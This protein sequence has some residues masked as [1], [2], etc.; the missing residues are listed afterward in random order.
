MKRF[1]SFVLFALLWLPL[2]ILFVTVV[3]GMPI[4]IEPQAWL[5]LAVV[6]P[7]GLPLALA[8][9]ALRRAGHPVSAWA[10]FVVLAPATAVAALFAGLLGPLGIAIYAIV[11]SLPAWAVYAIFRHRQRQ[12]SSST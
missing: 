9:R 8:C 7:F 6:A 5:A 10:T 1:S 11:L 2:G 12:S 3:R 4:F